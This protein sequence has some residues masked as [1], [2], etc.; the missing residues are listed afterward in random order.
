MVIT[1]QLKDLAPPLALTRLRLTI[2]EEGVEWSQ[3]NPSDP[4]TKTLLP[5]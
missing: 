1:A 3:P 5:E 2:S 4:S